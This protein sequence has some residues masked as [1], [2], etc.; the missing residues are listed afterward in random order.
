M[1]WTI[2]VPRP[3]VDQRVAQLMIGQQTVVELTTVA[4]P[5]SHAVLNQ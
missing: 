3:D 2:S 4:V 5:V 1:Q